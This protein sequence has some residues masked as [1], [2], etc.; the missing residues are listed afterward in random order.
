[1]LYDN[2]QLVSTYSNAY[3]ISKNPLYKEVVEETLAFIERELM[4]KEFGF[5]SSLDADSDNAEGEL[6]EGAF[7]VWTPQELGKLLGEDFP[8]FRDYYNINEF[9]HWEHQNYV[10]IRNKE[11]EV[12]AQ[13]NQITNQELDSKI[14]QWKQLLFKARAK[15]DFPRLDDKILTSWNA[16]MLN[17][18][19]DAYKTF[20]N[21][22]YL[23]IA[24]KNANFLIEKQLRPDGG[25]NHSYKAS[26]STIN[27][28][29]EDYATLSEALINLYEVTLDE[30]W[31]FTA[32]D[33]VNY[34]F[35]H[36]FDD[37]SKFFF[38]TSNQDEVI[39]RRS[40]EKAD[41]VI[42][43][44][45]SI[46]A[47]S[48]FKLSHYFFNPQYQKTAEQMLIRLHDDMM[49]HGSSYSNWLN[50]GLDFNAKFYEIA[51]V[52]KDAK[53]KVKALNKVYIPNKIISGDTKA[54][55]LPL[56]EGKFMKD[57]T[58]IFVCINNSCKL[59]VTEVSEALSQI[60]SE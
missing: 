46:M 24:L 40:I 49:Q 1:M 27:G 26:K 28:Y 54:S 35:D 43:A 16:L 6:E 39:V 22:H 7:Y 30:K 33:L 31:L 25:L 4:S 42:P 41:N 44:S 58:M 11:K 8:I 18:Y 50:L 52:G 32:R 38:F 3:L 55:K 20:G 15:R 10:L 14:T 57:M 12:I 23:D 2:G 29:L 36:F 17:G 59:P 47:R 19:I 56:L 51:V 53:E 13:A 34:S 9:G 21:E 45:N 37:T 48:L 5:Y 60:K